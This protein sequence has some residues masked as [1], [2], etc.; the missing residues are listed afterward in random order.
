M[1]LLIPYCVRDLVRDEGSNA[2][3]WRDILQKAD[4]P[5]REFHIWIREGAVLT[6][7]A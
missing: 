4:D 6:Q 1:F 7:F 2:R 5:S 3:V